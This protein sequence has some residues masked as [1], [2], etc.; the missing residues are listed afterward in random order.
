MY[1]GL[2]DYSDP[3]RTFDKVYIEAATNA[4]YIECFR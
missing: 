2:E 4:L 3:Y 1:A